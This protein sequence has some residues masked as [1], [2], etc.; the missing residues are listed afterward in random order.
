MYIGFDLGREVA[1]W[2]MAL[3]ACTG[4]RF[5]DFVVIGFFL[6]P[7]SGHGGRISAYTLSPAFVTEYLRRWAAIQEDFCVTLSS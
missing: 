5:G 6:L 2:V 4:L 7:F 1:G 3:A